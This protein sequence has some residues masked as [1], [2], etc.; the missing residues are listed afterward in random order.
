L[1]A[2]FW[3]LWIDRRKLPW[4]K[5]KIDIKEGKALY[6]QQMEAFHD[7]RARKQHEKELHVSIKEMHTH[8]VEEELR[9]Q[10]QQL[11][12]QKM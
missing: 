5:Q 6:F 7:A 4:A 8:I 1:I 10:E 2:T 11:E 12:K 3:F 9:L